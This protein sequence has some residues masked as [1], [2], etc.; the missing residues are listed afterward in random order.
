MFGVLGHVLLVGVKFS[1]AKSLNPT[2]G[3]KMMFFMSLLALKKGAVCPCL[4]SQVLRTG[5]VWGIIA[6]YSCLQSRSS[7]EVAV[8]KKGSPPKLPPHTPSLNSPELG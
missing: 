4:C 2:L 6:S 5:L 8:L 3:I 7:C 1:F